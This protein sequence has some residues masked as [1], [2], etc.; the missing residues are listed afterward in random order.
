MIALTRSERLMLTLIAR[1]PWATAQLNPAYMREDALNVFHHL[2]KSGMVEP[3]TAEC[4]AYQ[5][6]D[7]GRTT[8]LAAQPISLFDLNVKED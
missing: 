1:M 6:S 4:Y 3:V 7:K 5:I 8:L 2:H